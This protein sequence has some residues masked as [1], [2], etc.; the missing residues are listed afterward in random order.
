MVLWISNSL[1]TV[2][3]FSSTFF[4]LT[5]SKNSGA[6][7]VVSLTK[8]SVFI[9]SITGFFFLSNTTFPS[10]STTLFSLVCVPFSRVF[11][12][13]SMIGT[14][15]SSNTFSTNSPGL[16]VIFAVFPSLSMK[17]L[18][19]FSSFNSFPFVST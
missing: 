19:Y 7:S 17:L 3:P 16:S 4:T 15:I 1:M 10:L 11:P 6:L 14:V 5:F 12:S 2:F 8:S 9:V 13:L 18:R